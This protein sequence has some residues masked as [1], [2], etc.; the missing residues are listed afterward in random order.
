MA[1]EKLAMGVPCSNSACSLKSTCERFYDPLRIE[2][3]L[4]GETTPALG[5]YLVDR[6]DC[7][8]LRRRL[9]GSMD[10]QRQWTKTTRRHRRKGGEWT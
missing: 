2:Y 10:N 9:V 6:D 7:F 3:Q 8:V 5:A 4:V 1:A